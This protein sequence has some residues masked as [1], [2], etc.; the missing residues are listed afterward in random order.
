MKQYYCKQ[1][2]KNL[3]KQKKHFSITSRLNILYKNLETAYGKQG[4]ILKASK[5]DAIDLMNSRENTDRILALK[6]IMEENPTLNALDYHNLA[7]VLSELEASLIDIVAQKGLEAQFD[8]RIQEKM[9]EKYEDYVKDVKKQLIKESG[10]FTENAQTLK[11]LGQLEKMETIGLTCSALELLRPSCWEEI[12]GQ[13]KAIKDLISK[14]N[15]PYPQHI[16]LYGPPGVG[17]TSSARLALEMVKGNG[18]SVFSDEA[19]FVEVDGTTLRWDPRESTNPL[20]GSVHDPIYQG[21]RKELAEEGIPEPKM[22]LVSQAH[23]GVLFIDEI[24]DMEPFLQNKLLKVMEDKRVFFE[25]SYYDPKDERIPQYIKKIFEEGIPADFVLIG[26][27]TKNQEEINPAFRSRCMEVFFEA[28]SQDQIE[29]IIKKSAQ[30][31]K[32]EMEEE[33]IELIAEYTQEGRSANKLLVDAYALALYERQGKEDELSFKILKKHVYESIQNARLSPCVLQK[34]STESRVGKIFGI[35]VSGYNAGLIE[36]E[37]VFFLSENKDNGH[38]RFNDSAGTMTKD[39]VFNAAAVYRREFNENLNKYDIHIN[40]VGG[41]RVDG[42]SAGTAIYLSILSAIKAYPIKQD[43]ALTGELSI[44]GYVKKVGGIMEKIKGAKHAGIRKILIPQE[45]KKD[46]PSDIE[47][48]EVVYI[49]HVQE[50]YEH[51]FDNFIK[52]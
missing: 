27:T 29:A 35:G 33:S 38:I 47:G 2:S 11:K 19:P 39:S 17:K 1:K 45:N 5:L 16:I 3:L 15:S 22:G 23:S 37:S 46:I 52:Q 44:Q 50:S 21:A 9:E 18:I 24:G 26:A 51:I 28:L 48:I 10:N 8:R 40:I 34:A 6:R 14:M 4:L 32:I 30:K 41:G 43:V 12:V 42:P 49:N 13:D 25:S 31:L 7:D 20:L 36:I